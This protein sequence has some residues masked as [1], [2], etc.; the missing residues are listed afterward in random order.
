MLRIPLEFDRKRRC[1]SVDM[2]QR[3]PRT[4]ERSRSVH[5]RH[6]IYAAS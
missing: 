1:W 6:P 4:K 5:L 2:S 3:M